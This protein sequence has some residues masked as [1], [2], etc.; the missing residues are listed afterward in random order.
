MEEVN[1][2]MAESK[3]VETFAFQAE[4][5][6]AAVLGLERLPDLFQLSIVSRVHLLV[7]RC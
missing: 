2:A 6:P 1:T 4:V 7:P 3:D 5:W